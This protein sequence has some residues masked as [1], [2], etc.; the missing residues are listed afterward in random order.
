MGFWQPGTFGHFSRQSGAY[1][2]YVCFH[3]C[4]VLHNMY[5]TNA[6]EPAVVVL[7]ASCLLFVCG[8]RCVMH[9]M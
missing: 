8:S 1:H 2:I 4:S 7:P 6:Q 5:A 3:V 9:G